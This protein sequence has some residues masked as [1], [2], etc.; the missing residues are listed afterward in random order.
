MI[1]VKLG[2]GYTTKK[3]RTIRSYNSVRIGLKVKDREFAEEFARCL[4]KVLGRQPPKP[5]Y[6][7]HKHGQY[8]VEVHSETLYEL[9]KKPVNLDELRKYIEHCEGCMASFLRG[10]F[11]SEGSVDKRGY[12]RTYN[13][14][15][16]LLTYVKEL[17][18]QRFCVEVTGPRP[19]DK[20]GGI[21]QDPITGKPYI[22]KK[23]CYY[24]HIRTC[25]NLTFYRKVGF[26]IKRKQKRLENYIKRCQAK[27]PSPPS[28]PYT[29][30][31][32]SIYIALRRGRDLNPRGRKATGLADQPL[33]LAWVPRLALPTLNPDTTIF[34][35][36]ARRN[37]RLDTGPYP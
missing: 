12:I 22:R 16:V 2:D 4:A 27:P 8:V 29:I 32:P 28:P 20:R 3:R 25:C 18:E 30:L 15:L 34:V 14:D 11:D 6:D 37:R 17:L 23:D 36:L 21:F 10:F 9:L 19:K 13:T 33:N 7:K 1:G 5:F 31:N 26:T 35:S 24:I